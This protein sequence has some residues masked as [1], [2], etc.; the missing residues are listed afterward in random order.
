MLDS[1][2]NL[3][4]IHY[5]QSP[6][7]I[8]SLDGDFPIVGTGGVYGATNQYLYERGIVVARKGS[9]GNPHCFFTPFWPVD[10]TYAVLPKGD[11]SLEWLF[12]CLQN[13]DLSKLNEA[14]GVPSINRNWLARISFYNPGEIKQKKIATILSTIDSTIEHT[15]ALIE[16]YQNIKTGLMQDLF[17]RGLLPNGQ[18]RPPREQAPEL[19]QKTDIGWIPRDWNVKK[20]GDLFHIQ[21]G[22]MLS[23]A[24]KTGKE[25][26]P[27]LANRNVQWDRLWIG[28]LETME[29]TAYEREKFRLE[30]GDLL[31]CEGGDVGRTAIWR[32]ELA[33]CYYQ[34]AIHRLRPKATDILPWF[35][36]RFMSYAKKTGM[37]DNF[38]SQTSIAHLTQEKLSIIA[39]FVPDI[40]EQELVVQRIDSID[41]VIE[42]ET[43]VLNKFRLKKL[44]LMQDLLTGKV[45]VPID[46]TQAEPAPAH[47]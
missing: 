28:E 32:D 44:G 22:K 3:A 24:A 27:Y 23:K 25:E 14:T 40:Q 19:Y 34:K 35:M 21:L 47:A 15:E 37:F 7:E 43:E 33:D 30:M 38:T 36:L 18:L 39:M 10:T 8:A 26:F 1:L 16:K 13:F 12:Y 20:I 9:L 29:F 45:P 4:T 11:V 17:T 41:A 46:D 42:Q 6:K 5:G 2:G 31:V